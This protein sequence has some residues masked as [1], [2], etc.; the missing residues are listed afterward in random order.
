MR[1]LANSLKIYI[2]L[3]IVLVTFFV[4]RSYSIN[5]VTNILQDSIIKKD[6][7]YIA[8]P[9]D[10]IK[11]KNQNKVKLLSKEG[12]I[13]KQF[14]KSNDKKISEN[15]DTSKT[16]SEKNIS[17]N[18]QNKSN[19]LIFKT[20][21]KPYIHSNNNSLSSQPPVDLFSQTNDLNS[22]SK[23]ELLHTVKELNHL[24]KDIYKKNS[25][26][27]KVNPFRWLL[28]L[29]ATLLLIVI[30]GFFIKEIFTLILIAVMLVAL[31]LLV[32][33]L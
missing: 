10:S 14:A 32:G 21:I 9:D 8:N 25:E 13:F 15:K 17:K 27:K 12:I 23:N 29:I 31:V 22:I 33:F 4:P 18:N 20:L 6:K 3:I 2:P 24:K 5:T 16:A 30:L 7:A 26:Q 1:N 19:N 28:L 11:T